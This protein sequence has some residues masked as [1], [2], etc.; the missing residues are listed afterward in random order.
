LI[1]FCPS[2]QQAPD[3][4]E[5]ASS[6][7]EL[8]SDL[9]VLW[10]KSSKEEFN[11]HIHTFLNK[12][13]KKAPQYSK[14]FHTNWLDRHSPHKWAAYGRCKDMLSGKAITRAFLFADKTYRIRAGRGIQ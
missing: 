13:D 14:Y 1:P 12:W 9:G 6:I 10:E 11:V 2:K 5:A 7:T 8:S 4:V 3:R